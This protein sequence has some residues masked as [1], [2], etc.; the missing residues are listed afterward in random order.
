MTEVSVGTG[1][2][3][4]EL[5]L[6]AILGYAVAGGTGAIVAVVAVLLADICMF[7]GLVPVG[8]PFLYWY[9]LAPWIQSVLHS[10][11]IHA[12]ALA[13]LVWVI[14]VMGLVWSVFISAVTTF[15]TA[16]VVAEVAK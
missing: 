10:L 7:A 13:L 11:I 3:V 16:V 12:P 8:G 6:F 9:M 4:V 2:W 1:A 5:I 15:L 14:I